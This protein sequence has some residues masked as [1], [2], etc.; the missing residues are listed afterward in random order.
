MSS[1]EQIFDDDTLD[2]ALPALGWNVLAAM[3]CVTA[4]LLAPM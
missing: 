2:N 3:V 1:Q 4:F